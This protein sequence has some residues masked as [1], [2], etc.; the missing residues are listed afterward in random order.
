MTMQRRREKVLPIRLS[1]QEYQAAEKIAK[2]HG[3]TVSSYIRLMTTIQAWG[4]AWRGDILTWERE[5][6][7]TLG[8]FP[9]DPEELRREVLR[10][11]DILRAALETLGR[12][13]ALVR[14]LRQL[15]VPTLRDLTE[16][17]TILETEQATAEQAVPK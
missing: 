15:L 4:D 5:L 14:P 2:A 12:V 3:E 6:H 9:E 11:V 17:L 8:Q 7:D 13:D 16:I 1:E 10:R